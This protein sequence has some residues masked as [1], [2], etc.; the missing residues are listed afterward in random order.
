MCMGILRLFVEG[1]ISVAGPGLVLEIGGDDVYSLRGG[2]A[3]GVE[4]EL[5]IACPIAIEFGAA[6]VAGYG[7]LRSF[8]NGLLCVVL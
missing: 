8:E 7:S 2:T 3:L 5:V 4:L 1:E 6:Y